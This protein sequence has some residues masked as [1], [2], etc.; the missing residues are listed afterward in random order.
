MALL[1]GTTGNDTIHGTAA[2][3]TI[4]SGAGHDLILGDGLDG[5]HAAIFPDPS[6][7]AAPQ[8]NAIGA[9]DGNDTVHAGYGADTVHGDAGDDLILGW[10][11]LAQSSLYRDAYARDA[12][13]GD[14][15]RG[16]AG[17]DTLRGG[18]GRDLL[19]GGAGRDV[20]D[21]G[22]GADTLHGGAGADSF[23]FGALDA[24][25]R[26][27]IYDTPGDVVA[28]FQ[29]G[30]DHLDLS[31]FAHRLPGVAT[32]VLADIAFTDPTHLQVRSVIMGAD[33]R[34]DIHLPGGGSLGV[35]AS[36]TLLGL[37]HLTAADGAL[38][39]NGTPLACCGTAAG[40]D[41]HGE[42]REGPH[43]DPRR[44]AGGCREAPRRAGR[45]LVEDGIIRAVGPSLAAPEDARIEDASGLLLHPGL[46]NAAYPRP[47]RPG[48]R[49]GG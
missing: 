34:V 49:P 26:L 10:G 35:D 27:P 44:A 1:L 6:G 37:H 2:G 31:Q 11:V 14:V 45:L 46:I 5:P 29:G 16:D 19:D 28:D 3:D 21:G 9:G 4:R 20:L 24:R 12:D 32:D 33:T 38:R 7:G 43:P 22:T 42:D 41:E 40:E 30:I 13:G 8:G 36:I 17:Q 18:G 15:L 47:C 39:L 48:A 25:A 23:V